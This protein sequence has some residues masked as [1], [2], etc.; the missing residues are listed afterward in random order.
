MICIKILI[1]GV[2]LNIFAT[3]LLF[4]LKDKEKQNIKDKFTVSV[5]S[6]LQILH[7]QDKAF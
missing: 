4:Q 1:D 7:L 6:C 5:Q 2:H 3:C